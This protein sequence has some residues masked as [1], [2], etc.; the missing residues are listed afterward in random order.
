MGLH[1]KDGTERHEVMRRLLLDNLSIGF[2]MSILTS[3]TGIYYMCAGPADAGWHYRLANLVLS[4]GSVTI[5]LTAIYYR[6]HPRS[7]ILPGWISF[8]IYF[9]SCS[10]Y[11]MSR[12]LFSYESGKN[13]LMVFVVVVVWCFGIFE[14]YPLASIIY[15]AA[16]FYVM[17]YLMEKA[18]FHDYD[19]I[20]WTIFFIVIMF[21][22][23]IRYALAMKNIY[24]SMEI[25]V[26]NQQLEYLS[27][28]DGLTGMYNRFYLKDQMKTYIGE[29]LIYA[30]LDIDDFKHY[31]DDYGHDYGDF[32]LKL[33]GRTALHNFDGAD[34]FRYGGDEI[35]IVSRQ[36]R[37]H[38]E[39]QIVSF[40]ND[41]R[42]GF[43][44]GST[45]PTFSL[46]YVCGK[47]TDQTSL[48]YLL[49]LADENLY[50]VKHLNKNAF[51]G[52]EYGQ[53]A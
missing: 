20:N 16:V 14:L 12:S 1:I 18:G 32:I 33:Y 38:F 2:L 31:N 5:L 23:V 26:R 35:L 48:R 44:K 21:L 34:I 17:Y 28:R 42:R 27:S 11:G 47:A 15:G 29:N 9:F 40:R 49:K 45:A 46:G 7:R 43:D 22:S 36:D 30:M 51:K 10:F 50:Q 52:S 41:L 24:N 19:V 6:L 13:Y 37:G 25:E 53:G 3:A 4:L 8:F 39:S